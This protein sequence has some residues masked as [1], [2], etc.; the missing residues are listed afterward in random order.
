MRV[1]KLLALLLC[2]AFI[3]TVVGCSTPESTDGTDTPAS[4]TPAEAPSEEGA[5]PITF[6]FML[7][8][9]TPGIQATFD[10]LNGMSAET[11]YTLELD[12]VSAEESET[13]YKL[14]FANDDYGDFWFINSSVFAV[15]LAGSPDYFMDISGEWNKSLD[16]QTL[17]YFF[18]VDGK[19]S[20]APYGSVL[21]FG[22]YYNEE[23]FNDLGLSVPTTWQELLDVCEEIAA[24]GITPVYMPANDVWTTQFMPKF[25]MLSPYDDIAALAE[26]MNTNVTK[27]ADTDFGLGMDQ[28]RELVELGYT[29]P[30]FL[31]DNVESMNA[32]FANDEFAIF[33]GQSNM[34]A[35]IVKLYPEAADK[36]RGAKAPIGE[37]AAE[38]CSFY[39]APYGIFMLD[40]IQDEALGKAFIEK[41]MS[42]EV[43]QV[44]FSA[45]PGAP[46][47]QGVDAE[48]RKDQADFY[49][50]TDAKLWINQ[51]QTYTIN[52]WEQL[53]EV[54]VGNKTGQEVST[55]FDE[56]T[57]QQ[58]LAAGDENWS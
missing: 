9:V 13:T 49:A 23:I 16:Q 8:D 21:Q 45:E 57:T 5:D 35:N 56:D 41:F 54:L 27:W 50:D 51:L 37:T 15:G 38:S 39:S 58:A 2:A 33:F 28:S 48:M 3:T 7:T 46:M 24:A 52:P 30:D 31:S 26:D 18:T 34:A 20:G 11:G 6:S 55:Y 1:K 36:L 43:Q 12:K 25:T 44:Y 14:R 19:L 4:E 10:Y 47:V 53:Q 29:N 42:A 40:S 22:M 32:A 17:D